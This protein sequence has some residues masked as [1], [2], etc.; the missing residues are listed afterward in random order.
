MFSIQYKCASFTVWV[1]LDITYVIYILSGGA[2]PFICSCA[3]IQY[4]AGAAGAEIDDIQAP[5]HVST[6][7]MKPIDDKR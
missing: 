4:Q 7:S 1:V 5:L 6:D 2:D 3:S